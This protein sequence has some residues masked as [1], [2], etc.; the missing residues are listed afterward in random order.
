VIGWVLLACCQ[1]LTAFKKCQNLNLCKILSASNYQKQK[2]KIEK[3]KQPKIH[4]FGMYVL[5]LT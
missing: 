2:K 4:Q 3:E 1:W 5:C